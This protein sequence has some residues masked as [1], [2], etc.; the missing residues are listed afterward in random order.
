MKPDLFDFNQVSNPNVIFSLKLPIT[1]LH[2]TF[3]LY[4]QAECYYDAK[5]AVKGS[6]CKMN[7]HV[8]VRAFFY[9]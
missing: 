4:P 2:L 8:C 5:N 3:Y 7:F 6:F 1:L 9:F